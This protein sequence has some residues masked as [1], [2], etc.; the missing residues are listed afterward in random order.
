[1]KKNGKE[2]KS[3]SI[4]TL[5]SIIKHIVADAPKSELAALFYEYRYAA[6]LLTMLEEKGYSQPLLILMT[7]NLMLHGLIT[8]FMIQKGL[9]YHENIL[10]LNQMKQGTETIQVPETNRC[11]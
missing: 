7:D 4:L 3:A 11:S 5:L 8:Q 2:F 9:K 10:Q 1:M 6:T